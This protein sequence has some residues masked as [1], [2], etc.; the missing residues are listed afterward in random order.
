MVLGVKAWGVC[1]QADAKQV[2]KASSGPVAETPAGA[3][4]FSSF[5]SLHVVLS[6][7]EFSFLFSLIFFFK[8]QHSSL[9]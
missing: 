8:F 6:Q 5:T 4:S 9:H 3:P 1:V 7:D 2:V